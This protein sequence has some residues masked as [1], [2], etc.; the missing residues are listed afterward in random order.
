MTHRSTSEKE[1][2]RLE[3]LSEVYPPP[4]VTAAI[5]LLPELRVI[6]GFALA[7]EKKTNDNGI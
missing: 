4:R 2:A 6:L 3:P 1:A 7:P 5:K